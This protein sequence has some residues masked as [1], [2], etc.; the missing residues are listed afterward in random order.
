MK[1]TPKLKLTH[2]NIDMELPMPIIIKEK[3]MEK[4]FC[5]DFDETEPAPDKK[6]LLIQDF[7]KADEARERRYL[8]LFPWHSNWRNNWKPA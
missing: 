5:S 7:L 3:E 8:S 1:K 4:V 2:I 6:S